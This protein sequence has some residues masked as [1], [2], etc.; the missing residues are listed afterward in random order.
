MRARAAKRAAAG[1]AVLV[2][3]LA[4]GG[5]VL[6]S[7]QR[8]APDA[9]TDGKPAVLARGAE[10]AAAPPSARALLPLPG[11]GH[12][13]ALQPI[14]GGIR[15][16]PPVRIA[17][18]SAG[19][20]ARIVPVHLRGDALEVPPVGRAGWFGGGP[21]PGEAGRAVVIGHLDTRRG[22]GLFAAVPSLERGA[23]LSV[24]D[25]DGHEHPYE[26]VG[27]AQ[28]EKDR[29]PVDHVFGGARRPVLVLVTCGGDYDPDDGYS[30]N[31]LLYARAA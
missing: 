10:R 7:A 5:V 15:P 24:T 28:V 11:A 29:F 14:T 19:V 23:R 30:D 26:V 9:A 16:A 3:A 18:P 8:H 2:P 27:A 20:E 22:P 1:L 21:R 25:S 6:A 17:I 12:R 4:A 13:A 31:V